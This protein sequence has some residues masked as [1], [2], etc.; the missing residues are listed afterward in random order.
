M[1]LS[2]FDSVSSLDIAELGAQNMGDASRTSS[3][4]SPKIAPSSSETLFC[5]VSDPSPIV[6]P[7]NSE[8]LNVGL[9]QLKTSIALD[10]SER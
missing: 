4:A 7:N 1:Y 9:V 3:A 8:K 5:N 6:T 10:N 2:Y